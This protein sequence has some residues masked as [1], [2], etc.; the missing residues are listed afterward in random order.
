MFLKKITIIGVCLITLISCNRTT[1]DEIESILN[2]NPKIITNIIEKNPELFMTTLQ[3]SA[4]KMQESMAKN[5]QIDEQKAIELAIKNPLQPNIRTDELIVGNKD[6]PIKIVE[7]SDFECPFC[8]RGYSTVK[9]LLNKYPGK[10]AFIYKHLPL[11]FH[12]QAQI[13]AEYYEAIRLQDPKKAILFH[14]QIFDNQSKLKEGTSF[15]DSIAKKIGANVSQIKKDI[16]SDKIQ[17]RIAQDK[18]EA[19]KFQMQGTPGF[20]INGV[21]LRGAYPI[22][23]FDEIIS[24]LN[25]L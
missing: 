8:L 4:K 19:A 1:K 7:Y 2:E 14:D 18:Q 10:I 11:D 5:K 12:P 13:S 24:K 6:A 17:S 25:I 20:L 3:S 16:K 23:A 22:E 9:Q 21:P 15:L